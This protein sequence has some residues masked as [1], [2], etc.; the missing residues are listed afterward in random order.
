MAAFFKGQVYGTCGGTAKSD[1]CS[2]SRMRRTTSCGCARSCAS[3]WRHE[4]VFG[5]EA[6]ALTRAARDADATIS[7]AFTHLHPI[8]RIENEQIGQGRAHL[9]ADHSARR[10]IEDDRERETPDASGCA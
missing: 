3:G 1:G 10:E 9:P 2:P 5:R 6:R 8:K 7:A 4:R